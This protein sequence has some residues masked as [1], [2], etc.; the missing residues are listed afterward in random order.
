MAKMGRPPVDKATLRNR[1]ITVT[2]T[3]AEAA[4]LARKATAA[5]LTMS[6]YARERICGRKIFA[7]G[8][9]TS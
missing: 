2:L 3:H 1:R 6:D 7:K 4:A 8:E 9:K 5:K